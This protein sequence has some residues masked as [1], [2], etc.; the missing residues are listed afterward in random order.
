MKRGG[1]STYVMS[2]TLSKS[3]V[4]FEEE[5]FIALG[6]IVCDPRISVAAGP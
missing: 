2:T 3:D 1:C 6:E 5:A 4:D